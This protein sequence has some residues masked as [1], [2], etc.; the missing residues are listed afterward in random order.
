MG[1]KATDSIYIWSSNCL[2][3]RGLR[4]RLAGT[5]LEPISDQPIR[6]AA[7]VAVVVAAIVVALGVTAN[8]ATAGTTTTAGMLTATF[9]F[10]RSHPAYPAAI[11]VGLAVVL[12]AGRG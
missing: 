10:T 2:S 3:M 8:L 4:R 9:D 5:I 11:I 7:G 12:L 1:G 6:A